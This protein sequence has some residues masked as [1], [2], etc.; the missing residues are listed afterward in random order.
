[1]R[2]ASTKAT[3]TELQQ[4]KEYDIN[5]REDKKTT[6]NKERE[7]IKTKTNQTSTKATEN[8]LQQ[9][10]NSPER[11]RNKLHLTKRISRREDEINY[12]KQRELVGD[13]TK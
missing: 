7:R 9:E 13:R 5:R 4:D 6:L 11:G 1:M 10:E 12:I 2:Q 3:R 8:E